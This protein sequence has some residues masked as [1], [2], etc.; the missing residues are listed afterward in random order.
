M[1]MRPFSHAFIYYYMVIEKME[2]ESWLCF[3]R[4]LSAGP[5]DSNIFVL[6]SLIFLFLWNVSM[7]ETSHLL[8]HFL[9]FFP[10]LPLYPFPFLGLYSFIFR[11]FSLPLLL[12]MG[13]GVFVMIKSAFCIRHGDRA[14]ICQDLPCINN[15]SN[16]EI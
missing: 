3:P 1:G 16:Y 12:L 6:V 10:L 15:L 9:S 11:L 7:Y 8:S 4:H 2:W 14:R 5:K 13:L